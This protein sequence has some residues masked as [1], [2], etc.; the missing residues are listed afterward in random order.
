MMK[1]PPPRKY[2][3]RTLSPD[4]E[5]ISPQRPLFITRSFSSPGSSGTLR[6][7]IDPPVSL[8]DTIDSSTTFNDPSEEDPPP[9]SDSRCSSYVTAPLSLTS[10][11]S[12]DLYA[13][14]NSAG[15]RT[16]DLLLSPGK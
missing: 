6:S 13:S 12:S 16:S 4:P 14:A 9:G 11:I 3:S 8:N 1:E 10:P 7:N 5:P 2:V 15:S